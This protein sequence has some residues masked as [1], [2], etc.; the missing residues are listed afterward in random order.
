MQEPGTEVP[1]KLKKRI[2]S[3]KGRHKMT[4]APSASPGLDGTPPT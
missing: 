2:E 3:R 1:G 4:F